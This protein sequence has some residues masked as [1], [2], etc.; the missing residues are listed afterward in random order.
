M[1]SVLARKRT[2]VVQED[3][4]DDSFIECAVPEILGID[5]A[6]DH[7]VDASELWPDWTCDCGTHNE[8][9]DLNCHYCGSWREDVDQCA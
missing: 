7:A 5:D 1:P 3:A 8:G 4:D 6:L 9:R 2:L